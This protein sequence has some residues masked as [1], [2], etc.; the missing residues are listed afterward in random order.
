MA[1]YDECSNERLMALYQRRLDAEAFGTLVARFM[2]PALGVAQQLLADRALAEDVVQETFLRLVSRRDSYDPS[3]PFAP[4]F[5]TIL[6]HNCADA[7]RRRARDARALQHVG[8]ELA[9]HGSPNLSSGDAADMLAELAPHD[10][11]VLELRVLHDLPFRDVAAALGISEEAAKK[12]AQRALRRLRLLARESD[13][14]PDDIQPPPDLSR[15]EAAERID[16]GNN[17]QRHCP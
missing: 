8:E 15:R 6:R 11:A 13:W 12:R 1:Q 16:A 17:W 2:A 3:S 4:W 14:A 10:R 9:R 5:Y 7:L